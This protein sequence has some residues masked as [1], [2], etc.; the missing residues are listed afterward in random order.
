LDFESP[1]FFQFKAIGN[2]HLLF[3]Q[4]NNKKKVVLQTVVFGDTSNKNYAITIDPKI[5]NKVSEIWS[6]Q[7]K[8]VVRK[9]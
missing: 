9:S 6:S 4:Y 1:I 2:S 3:Y 5:T 7:G 8:L